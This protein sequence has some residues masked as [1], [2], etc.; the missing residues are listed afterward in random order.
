VRW[1]QRTKMTSVVNPHAHAWGVSSKTSK[2]SAS[3]FIGCWAKKTDAPGSI[4]ATK[5]LQCGECDRRG[6]AD[7]DGFSGAALHLGGRSIA[8]RC[9]GIPLDSV[10]R[11]RGWN[12]FEIYPDWTVEILSPEQKTTKVIRNILH[13]QSMVPKGWLVDPDGDFVF[14]SNFP[15]NWC[16]DKFCVA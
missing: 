1:A 5:V 10:W 9:N 11:E 8:P 14:V 3:E 2:L 12:S 15:Q 7:C 6:T 16:N 4:P 13:H